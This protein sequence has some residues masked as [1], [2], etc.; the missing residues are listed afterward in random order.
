[1]LHS[2]GIKFIDNQPKMSG[3]FTEVVVFS[4][5]H[6]SLGKTYTMIGSDESSRTI[7][8]IP[9]A[10]AWLFRAIKAKKEKSSARYCK[11][12]TN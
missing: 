4:F 3:L 9:T 8:I 1:M 2:S 10:I 7:G 11:N 5:G 12:N 6:S